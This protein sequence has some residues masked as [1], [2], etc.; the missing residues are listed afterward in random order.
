MKVKLFP[1]LA[2]AL[3]AC[4]AA[5]HWG[6]TRVAARA[7]VDLRI[8]RRYADKEGALYVLAVG[9]N[10]Y[11]LPE[12]K[13]QYAKGRRRAVCRCRRASGRG[14]PVT[15][16]VLS[17]ETA[18]REIIEAA[19]K[20]AIAKVRPEDTFVFHFAGIGMSVPGPTPVAPSDFYLFTSDTNIPTRAETSGPDRQSKLQQATVKGI[21]TKLLASWCAKIEARN[22]LIVLDSCDSAESFGSVATRIA[23][24]DQE[25]RE[26]LA[27]NV[28]VL[29][30]TG[31][32]VESREL[33][34]GELTYALLQG[35]KGEA[36]TIQ[37]DGQISVRELEGYFYGRFTQLILARNGPPPA[38]ST[39]GR[40]F[41]LG[42]L[43][44]VAA[45]PPIG[46]V[47]LRPSPTPVA[48]PATDAVVMR[49]D[50]P[51]PTQPPAPA[52]TSQFANE[53]A[54]PTLPVPR[55]GKDYALLIATD[56]YEELEPLS[57]PVQDAH[58]VADVLKSDYGFVTEIVENPAR[59][60][61]KA[62][63]RRYLLREDFTDE[64]QL[65][66]FIAGHGVYD[67]RVKEG[68]VAARDSKKGDDGKDS[69]LS[70]SDLRTIV[71]N[72]PCKHVFIVLDVCFGGAFDDNTSGSRSDPDQ[73]TRWE[74]VVNNMRWRTRLF[75][76]S[77]GRAYVPDGRP[78]ASSPF[79]RK[80][81]EA[82]RGGGGELGVLTYT[83]ILGYV[84]TVKPKPHK[85]DFGNND[86]GSDFVFIARRGQP[87]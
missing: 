64:D 32:T 68:Y 13:Q 5:L 57:N 28:V 30:T 10:T 31:L 9:I 39:Y 17:D 29:G 41:T 81:L 82:L 38:S 21:S 56:K 37:R 74:H 50:A 60:E 20:R 35:L 1:L 40:D 43:P 72:I 15:K 87:H 58:K 34:H 11:D 26:L 69:Y 86:P 23:G 16:V 7:A 47:R 52:R 85:G 3:L 53:L 25:L 80:L 59:A 63:L 61:L 65:F 49:G 67:E 18:T 78:G 54:D 24:G 12:Y 71:N 33:G 2:V 8:D 73:V 55:K 46:A 4:V 83:K 36:D 22:Q 62:V 14:R 77:G 6:D 19:F 48:T 45:L 44:E 66:I 51:Q 84:E 42:R 27:K 70:H 75:L 79:A 76:T